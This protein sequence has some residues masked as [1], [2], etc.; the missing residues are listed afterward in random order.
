MK[1]LKR[2]IILV[3]PMSLAACSSPITASSPGCPDSEPFPA[4]TYDVSEGLL[5][6]LEGAFGVDRSELP[7]EVVCDFVYEDE[8]GGESLDA[9]SC[10]LTLEEPSEDSEAIVGQV[11]CE[12]ETYDGCE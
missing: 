3:L 4:T 5:V 1:T 8:G 6:E 12:G 7:C 2:L 9:S 11:E 10:E